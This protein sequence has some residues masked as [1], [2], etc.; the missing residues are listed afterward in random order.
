VPLDESRVSTPAAWPHYQVHSTPHFCKE[1]ANTRTHAA[2]YEGAAHGG[3]PNLSLTFAAFPFNADQKARAER[4][5]QLDDG[6]FRGNQ[7]LPSQ[8][9]RNAASRR[10]CRSK[11]ALVR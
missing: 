6:S 11:P 3:G 8:G 7:D 9:R 1:A 2:R 10:V 5:S 4:H